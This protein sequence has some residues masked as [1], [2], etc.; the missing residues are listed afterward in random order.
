[1]KCF[2]LTLLLLPSIG[3]S[4]GLSP[5]E[6]EYNYPPFKNCG[7]VTRWAS[8]QIPPECLTEA[9]NVYFD[10]DLSVTRRK[11]TVKY[12]SSAPCADAKAIKGLWN[13][14]S[15][16]GQKYIVIFSSQTFFYTKN[17]ND[18]NAIAGLNN[19]NS[20][21]TP[22]CVQALGA[23]YCTN[24]VNIPWY[25]NG[26]STGTWGYD[27]LSSSYLFGTEIGTFRNRVILG[28]VSGQPSRIL[29]SGE[30]DASDWTIKIP[31]V[32]TTPASI[33]ISGANDGKA[34]VALM[35]QYQN[36][37]YIGRDDDLYSLS[38]GDR[39]NF[40]L[41]QVSSQ[42][43]VVDSHSVREKDNCLVWLSHR[44]V[45]KLCGTTIQRV[46]DPIRDTVDGII[47]S[48]PVARLKNYTTETD[49]EAGLYSESGLSTTIYPGSVVPST[50]GHIDSVTS[51]YSAD[52]LVGVTT[53][54]GN[55]FELTFTTSSVL[56][57]NFANLNLWSQVGDG[58]WTAEYP[59]NKAV[60][61]PTWGN[62]YNWTSGWLKTSTT[63]TNIWQWRITSA[64]YDLYNTGIAQVAS[65]SRYY[66]LSDN[67]DTSNFNGYAF[68][69]ECL[70]GAA[71]CETGLLKTVA[72]TETKLT[73]KSIPYTYAD[74][75]LAYTTATCVNLDISVVNGVLMSSTGSTSSNDWCYH[76]TSGIDVSGFAAQNY[77]FLYGS[78]MR[79]APS[80]GAVLSGI[81]TPSFSSLYI[82]S[83]GYIGGGAFTGIHTSTYIDTTFL[84]PV[85]GPF[86]F[87]NTVPVGSTITY[88]VRQSTANDGGGWGSWTA[89]STTTS[90]AYRVP[91]TKRY[92]QYKEDFSTQYATQ[93]PKGQGVALEATTTGYYIGDCINST[94]LSSWGNFKPVSSLTG[95]SS[96]NYWVSTGTTCN[97]VTRSTVNWI[98]Q[99]ANAPVSA[100]TVTYLGFKFEE[101]PVTTTDTT[102]LNALTVDWFEGD[103]RPSL[104]SGMYRE[105]YFLFYTTNTGSSA[106]NDHAV[107]LDMND[108]WSFLDDIY[109]NAS[110]IYSTN[111]YTGDSRSGGFINQQDVGMNDNG[112]AYEFKIKTNDY[113][114]GNPVELKK[115]KRLYV[116]T[117]SETP[118]QNIQLSVNYYIDGGTTPYSLGSAALSEALEGGYYAAKFPAINTQPSTF[119]WLSIS[120]AYSGSQWPMGVDSI[121][122]IYSPLRWD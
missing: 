96:I 55:G 79:Y 76:T 117:H 88:S 47:N 65:K 18:C 30:G 81:G 80:Y 87:S 116:T 84:T 121:K 9:K 102:R 74:G 52:S 33:D 59:V 72:G 90:G 93:T 83:G 50:W 37:F 56:Y 112:D 19:L 103:S 67:L 48:A 29:L 45:E 68:Y 104:A 120:I 28:N 8:D 43:G 71:S 54:A 122:V 44:G 86:S 20:V 3:F 35:G 64:I 105:K 13:F 77:Q 99:T 73:T 78:A 42:I 97:Q 101:I 113:D 17:Q 49:F 63:T 70:G 82:S 27:T 36:A 14:N 66:F 25:W 11:G 108:K 94:G 34:I 69:M 21:A 4:Q 12:N 38:G 75:T 89:V 119:R 53:A 15:T 39:R 46:S 98:S 24:G 5:D 61:F 6:K 85:G 118:G 22:N 91:F 16:D 62:E 57:D 51:D 109:V 2:L 92:W 40:D 95:G 10:E 106:Y 60:F 1:M 110:V 7:L 114:F 107:V 31:G 26:T 41:R 58:F 100:S 111:F 115:L 32:S 23:L